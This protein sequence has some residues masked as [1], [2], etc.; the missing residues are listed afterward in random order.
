MLSVATPAASSCA[1]PI[2][3]VPSRNCTMPVG[4]LAE[5]CTLAVNT[6]G[7]PSTTGEGGDTSV[8]VGVAFATFKLR[9]A[10][11]NEYRKSPPYAAAKGWVP[12]GSSAWLTCAAF[13]ATGLAPSELPPSANEIFPVGNGTLAGALSVIFAVTVTASPYMG[14]AGCEVNA[15][16]VGLGMPTPVAI[17]VC[18][19][20]GE[21]SLSSAFSE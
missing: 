8:I 15:S 14:A 1:V 20:P 21:L 13:C 18:G 4:V 10:L 17:T 11:L 5:N 16:T 7:E 12:A 2:A 3:V 19:V 6:T 9:V